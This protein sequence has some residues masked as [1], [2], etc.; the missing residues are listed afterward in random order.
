[1][2]LPRTIGPLKK[3][4][5]YLLKKLVDTGTSVVRNELTAVSEELRR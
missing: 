2:F 5:Q 4:L 1:M 3:M